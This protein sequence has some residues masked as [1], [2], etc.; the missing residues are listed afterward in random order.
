MP[1]GAFAV[2]P[3]ILVALGW[4]FTLVGAFSCKSFKA[5][6]GNCIYFDYTKFEFTGDYYY[7]DYLWGYSYISD[8]SDTCENLGS[9]KD[10][11]IKAGFAFG[12]LAAIF[13]ILT[14]FAVISTT[15][16]KSPRKVILALSSTCFVMALFSL[17]VGTMGFASDLC[18]ANTCEMGAGAGLA[19]AAVILW[20]G[21]GVSLCFLKR[22][23][24]GNRQTPNVEK[25]A[26]ATPVVVDTS[27]ST[28]D[29]KISAT[30]PAQLVTVSNAVERDPPPPYAQANPVR[31]SRT[32][33]NKPQPP[34]PP[35]HTHPDGEHCSDCMKQCRTS[36]FLPFLSRVR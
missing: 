32:R 31:D 29:P 34:P 28:F 15:F 30:T 2:L 9:L 24:R 17:L 11:A 35:P 22:F 33:R 27:H 23:E 19:I 7:Y 16:L 10:G 1:Q 6:D 36:N 8:V 18:K 20:I 21:A 3:I 14:L 5:C 25:S 4:I 13:G 26:I 12:I